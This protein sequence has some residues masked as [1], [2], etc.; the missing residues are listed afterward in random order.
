MSQVL[1]AC[2]DCRTT[3]DAVLFAGLVRCG[4]CADG[5]IPVI[6]KPVLSW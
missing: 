4:S 3:F 1:V 6:P 5:H 2:V